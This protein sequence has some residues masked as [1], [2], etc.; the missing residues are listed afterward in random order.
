[1]L[2]NLEITIQLDQFEPRPYQKPVFDAFINKGYKKIMCIWP[3]RCL[4]GDTH[5]TMADGSF[6]FLRDIK[7]G[8][9]ILSWNGSSFEPDVVKN[10]WK[11][12]S[13]KTLTINAKA[14]PSI[15]TSEDHLFAACY[16]NCNV[17]WYKASDLK[18]LHQL[19]V[20]GG[21]ECGSLH[22]PDLAEFIGYMITDGYVSGYQQPKFTNVN[23]EI[24][25]RVE[26]LALKLFNIVAV[27]RGKGNAYDLGL[28]NGSKGG[29]YT[30]NKIKMLFRDY[31]LDVPKSIRPIHPLVW[32]FDRESLGRF[33]AA[34]L[35]CDGSI[36]THK[37]SIIHDLKRDRH[38]IVKPYTEISISCGKSQSYGWGMYWLFRKIGIQPQV[39][40]LEHG[41]S[42]FKISIGRHDQIRTLLSYGPVYGKEDKQKI[43]LDITDNRELMPYSLYD[44]CYRSRIDEIKAGPVSELYDIETEKNHNF[45]ANGYV[46]HNSGKDLVA[47]Q[48][49][50]RAALTRVGI[51]FMVYPT[52]NQAKKIVWDGM[53]NTGKKFLDFIPKELIENINSTEMKIILKNGSL[54][55]LVGSTD[56]GDR[57][58]GSNPVGIVFS[59]FALCDA[60]CYHLC[61]PMLNA[62]NGWAII[63][64]TPRGHNALYQLYEI[65]R[66]TPEWF[67]S[68]L[69]LDDT[70]HIPRELIENEIISGEI[71]RDLS[72]QEYYT[73][74]SCGQAGSF[75]GTI[76]DSMRLKGQIGIVPYEPHH[77][78]STSCDIGLDTTAILFFQVV[79]SVIRIIDYYENQNLSLDHYL[80]IIKNK[81]Y[82]Y[83]KHIAPHDMSNREFSSGISRLEMARR[84]DVR[85]MLAPNLSIMD[86]VEAVRALLARCFIDDRACSQLI[87]CI[88]HYRQS[89]DEKKKTY[90]GKP[91][92]DQ[93]SHGC[94]ALRMLA[95]TLPKISTTTTPEE[96]ENRYRQAVLGP[97]SS[98]PSVFRTDLP[99][100]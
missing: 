6:K 13:K 8:D 50:L 100:Y 9:Q 92:H 65:A 17:N 62:N 59:E 76:L 47:L 78:V 16:Q 46:V 58:V 84:L 39:P 90:T 24:L 26:Y 2:T 86:G 71:S 99:N 5:I 97:N 70:M 75:Y 55:Q 44:G 56:A 96:L 29:G 30:P 48:L 36:Y 93:Y 80:N 89:Y 64:S 98:L 63:L 54:I 11:T 25:K 82:T 77:L 23:I 33:F 20:Y 85:F 79:G 7:A 12:E 40:K 27:W 94:D 19:Q 1:M 72:L 73:S 95:V 49:L 74:F 91:E 61:R 45:I 52:Y 41:G 18:H 3:R 53:T 14:W 15:V 60:T 38:S 4:H 22:D 51:Y 21:I 35:S 57:I 68:K 32:Q 88:E 81:P 87:K 34:V 37:E 31:S 83:N 66:Q 28:T 67:V 43:A 10:A 42:N 69:T